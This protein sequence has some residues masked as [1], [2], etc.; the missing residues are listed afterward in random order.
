MFAA[1]KSAV[2]NP[3]STAT[4]PYKLQIATPKDW[5]CASYCQVRKPE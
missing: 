1:Q 2:S 3:D 4:L 5:A